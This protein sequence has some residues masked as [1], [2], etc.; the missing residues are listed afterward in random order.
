MFLAISPFAG[1]MF[2]V[3]YTHRL[4]NIH[5]HTVS[6]AGLTFAVIFARVIPLFEKS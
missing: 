1:S 5:I 6:S 3:I 4:L 2:V